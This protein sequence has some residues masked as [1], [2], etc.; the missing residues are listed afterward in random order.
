MTQ[1][2]NRQTN[3]AQMCQYIV[4]VD[5]HERASEDHQLVLTPKVQILGLPVDLSPMADK[6]IKRVSLD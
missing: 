4:L 6:G 3:V 1:E 5:E 2:W